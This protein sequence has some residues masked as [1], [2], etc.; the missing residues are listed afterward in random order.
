MNL[1]G[2]F[3]TIEL[4]LKEDKVLAIIYFNRPSAKNAMNYEMLRSLIQ[5]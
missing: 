5:L 2:D 1:L 4:D 3:K